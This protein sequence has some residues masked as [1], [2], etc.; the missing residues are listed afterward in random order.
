MEG[1]KTEHKESI[2]GA[3]I[4]Q[5]F[6]NTFANN[7]VNMKP[8]DGLDD[9][10]ITIA[11]R[12]ATGTRTPLFVPE[13]AFEILVKRQISR[14]E[15]PSVECVRLVYLEIHKVFS[16]LE[17]KELSHYQNLRER[18]SVIVQDLL[19]KYLAPC[20]Q[21]INNL[22]KIEYAYINTNHDDFVGLESIKKILENT[23]SSQDSLKISQ[24]SSPVWPIYFLSSFDIYFKACQLCKS[25][26]EW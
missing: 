10:S 18:I 7:L 11:I 14:L 8:L 13:I 26:R 12:N 20:E 25:F 24:K 23:A 3:K 9:E 6:Y 16:Y 19:Q 5:I 21:M 1:G 15:D 2:G 17:D 22:L 4:Y